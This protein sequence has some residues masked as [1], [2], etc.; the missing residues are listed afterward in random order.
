MHDCKPMDTPVEINLSLNLDMCPKS[1][2]E[3]K[4]M[5]KVPYSSAIGSLMYAMI[6]TRPNKC[7]TV[8]LASR[9]QSNPDIKHWKA[10]KRI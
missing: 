7:Y 6:C 10:V 4:K 1:P 5:S 2:E 9:L 3:K 8:R